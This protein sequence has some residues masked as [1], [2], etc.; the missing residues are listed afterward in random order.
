MTLAAERMIRP[1]IFYHNG[2]HPEP[3]HAVGWPHEE[4]TIQTPDGHTLQGWLFKASQPGAPTLLFMHGTSYNASDMWATEERAAAFNEFLTG[5]R[6]NFFLFDYRGYG[7]HNG[8]ATEDG[9]YVDASA[10]LAWLHQRPDIDPARIFFYGF[11]MGTGVAT[12][13]AMREKSAGL[14]LRAPF[15]SVRAMAITR[16]PWMASLF[17]FTPWLPLTNYDT[18]RRIRRI[19]RPLLVMHGDRDTTVPD[20]MGRQVFDAAPEPKVFVSFP[21]TGHSDLATGLVVSAITEFVDSV[22]SGARI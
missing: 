1:R 18:L 9:T 3:P 17:A 4:A 5:I 22:L 13:L 7:R 2:W 16:H 11:S 8:E 21:D 10:A 6:A 19:D 12:G 14:I 15:T 20:Y